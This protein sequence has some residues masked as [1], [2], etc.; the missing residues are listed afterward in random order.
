MWGLPFT[1]KNI[2]RPGFIG[3]LTNKYVYE[4]LPEG[5]L[6]K[7]KEKTPRTKGGYWRYKFH[8][9]LTPEI[10]REE[11]KKVINTVEAYA[12]ISETKEEF[13]KLMERYRL[14]K[15]LP[16]ADLELID[17]KEK[18]RKDFDKKFKALLNV[19]LFKEDK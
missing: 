3:T 16:S 19:P 17:E 13:L 11:L 2:K 10:G 4:N 8:Q 9:S 18:I 1:V 14:Q 7:L 5:V 15:K 6:E 12:L